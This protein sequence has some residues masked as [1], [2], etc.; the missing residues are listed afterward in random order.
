M[1]PQPPVTR[2]RI[3]ARTS[4][5]AGSALADFPILRDRVEVW[6]ARLAET[7]WTPWLILGLAIFLRFFLLGIKPPHFD[8]GINGWFVDQVMKNG[9]YK[10]DPTNYHGPL[11]FYVVLISEALFGRNVWALRLPVV[12][13]SIGCVWLCFKFEPLVGRTVSRMAALAMAVSPGFVFFGRYS[14]HEVWLVLFSMM[15]I[16]GLLGLWKFGTPDYL[17]CA[18][19]GVAG[20]ILTKETYIIHLGCAALAIP[21]VMVSNALNQP[22]DAK[23]A[24]QKWDYVDLAIVVATGIALIVFFYS[25]TFFHWSGVKGI[26]QA[27]APWF[28]TGKAGH[29]HEKPWYY[30]LELMAP[31]FKAGRADV[32]GYELPALVGVVLCLFCQRFKN[33]SLRYL[34]IY[35]VGTLVAYSIV[36]YKT[37]WCIISFIWPFLFIFGAAASLTAPRYR[38]AVHTVSAVFLSVSL[39]STIWLNYFR[40]TTDTE[41]YV[42]V[43]T[44]NDIFKLTKPLLQLAHRD[45]RYYQLTG[46]MIRTSAYP[47]PWILGDFPHVGYY[48]H[49]NLP[50]KVDADF[51]LVQEDRIKEV[52]SKLHN[53]YYTEPLRIRAYQDTS[54]LYLSAKIFQEFFPGRSPDFVGKSSG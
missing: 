45:P 25:G 29:G 23:A 50:A 10:Y 51:L 26:Y 11:H 28:D 6:Q 30:W 41:P 40:C 27:Y 13:L 35:S 1:N 3:E 4:S 34:A 21:V 16:L 18:G 52:E 20:M 8:E 43:Q 39:G 5:G 47:L 2:M 48:E 38:T 36:P 15:F 12:L 49:Q 53:A 17:W 22:P 32:L 33:V 42:Y 14:I 46:H 31:S 19:M 24:K 44:Y 7:G 54:K 37:P 9:F